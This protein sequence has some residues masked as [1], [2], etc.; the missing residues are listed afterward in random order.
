MQDT[1]LDVGLMFSFRNPPA[2]RRPFAD[3]YADELAL[4]RQA[5]ELGY[6]TI[7]LTEHH[8][9]ED[10]Y[11]PS[12]ITIAAAVAAQTNRV[13]IGFNLLLLPLHHAVQV[14]EDLATLDVLS[15]GRI[16]VGLGQGYAVHEFAG[17]GIPRSERLGRFREGLDVLTGMW[18]EESFSY[19][20]VHYQIS[21]ARLEPRPVQQP[22]PPLWIGAT[23]EPGVR[24]AG[25]R[26]A[27]LLGLASRH[28]Q[29]LYEQARAD[30]GHDPATAKALHLHWTHLARDRRRGVGRGCPPLP[31]SA[32]GLRRLGQRLQR[33]R[34]GRAE[35]RHPT[36]RRAAQ[37]RP[38]AH[39]RPGLRQRRP[40]RRGAQRLDRQGTHHPPGARRPA[41]HGPRPDPPL[42][43]TVRRR[44]R[45]PTGLDPNW[46]PG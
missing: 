43:G 23:S 36:R 10:G 45:T 17:Y 18:T 6:D 39:V 8:F 16:D 9:A 35:G 12:I 30:A 22:M 15:N 7:W 40:R 27:N 14:A 5:E 13:R 37:P 28:L 31:S 26:G 11:S 19:D 46:S 42:D 24:R 33:R 38:Q 34:Q 32:R 1:T 2:W 4:I 3:V 20:G 41:R 25:R 44:R 29:E 21:D